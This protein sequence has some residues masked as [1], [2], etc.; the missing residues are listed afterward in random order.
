M[1]MNIS[2]CGSGWRTCDDDRCISQTWIC[3]GFQDCQDNADE[4]NCGEDSSDFHHLPAGNV[5]EQLDRTTS[6]DE[7]R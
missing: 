7:Y 4:A 2:A 3:D 5:I 6:S 1:S